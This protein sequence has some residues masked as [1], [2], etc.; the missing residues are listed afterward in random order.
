MT[1]D[2]VN[3][4]GDKLPL[5]S[6]P[7]FYLIDVDGQTLAQND[8]SSD[9]IG[10][11]DGDIVNDNRVQPRTIIL[12]LRIKPGE[13]VEEAKR[14]VLRVVKIKKTGTLIWTQNERTVEIHGIVEAV[15]MPRWNNAV[16][17]QITLH[18]SQ[19]FWE[20]AENAVQE[21]REAIGLHYF[22][23][24]PTDMLFF[25]D[26]GIVMSEYDFSRTKTVYNSGDVAVGM[27]IEILAHDTVTNP[28]IY[29]T[30]GSFFGVGSAVNPFVMQ[31]G[32]IMRINTRRGE[33]SVTLNGVSLW[34]K[35]KPKSTWIQMEAGENQFSIS[36]SDSS[37][38]N[39][40][41]SL[42]Y[43]RRYI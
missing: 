22:T 20:D 42:I 38:E 34:G 37:I 26:D 30:D 32:D 11:M 35:I 18:C 12:T 2:F 25:P 29:A 36:S 23:D 43:K 40:T 9:V 19:P 31:S 3:S 7:L 10:G 21:I 15:E 24:S 14:A 5:S 27:E 4:R 6:H 13:N 33:K 8:I 28:I 16:T 17:M 39:M 1:F 41:F